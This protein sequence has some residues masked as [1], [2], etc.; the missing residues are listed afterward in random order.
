MI[1]NVLRARRLELNLTQEELAKKMGYRSKSTINKI[2]LNKHDVNQKQLVKF[3]K[4]L[5]VSPSYFIGDMEI[6]TNGDV[7]KCTEM[8]SGLSE[9]NLAVAMQY[10]EYLYNTE[11]KG[12]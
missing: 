8:L 6:E 5:D 11:K 2:E 1:G 12:E 10:I 4:V 3:A 7:K 9:K